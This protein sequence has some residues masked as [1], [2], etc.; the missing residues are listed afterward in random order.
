LRWNREDYR[1]EGSL[2]YIMRPCFN[3]TTR[4]KQ[5]F[6]EHCKTEH[7]EFGEKVGKRK[8]MENNTKKLD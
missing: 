2:G 6:E 8:A 3:K 1:V 4:K 7:L 5:S